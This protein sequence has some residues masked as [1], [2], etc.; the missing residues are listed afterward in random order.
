MNI[1]NNKKQDFNINDYHTKS[2][3]DEVN[4]F[5][6]GNSKLKTGKAGKF[7]I[8]DREQLYKYIVN[9][10]DN[11]LEQEYCLTESIKTN[12]FKFYID[13][14]IKDNDIK[15]FNVKELNREKFIDYILNCVYDCVLDY[16]NNKKLVDYVFC[17]KN[18]NTVGFHLYFPNIIIN[19]PHAISIIN[20]II[21]KVKNENTLKLSNESS[22]FYNKVIDSSIYRNG[23]GSLRLIY[24]KS[25]DGT[26]KYVNKG[27]YYLVNHQKTTYKNFPDDNNKLQQLMLLTLSCENENK[28]NFIPNITDDEMKHIQCELKNKKQNIKKTIPI[29]D[30]TKII[31]NENIE[32]NP[33]IITYL[34][35]L[36]ISRFDNYSDWLNIG[37]ILYNYSNNNINYL[38]LWDTYS[39]KS[40][41][42]TS[43][44]EIKQK[45]LSFNNNNKSLTIGTLIFMV[46]EDN[47]DAYNELIKNNNNTCIEIP[48]FNP[49]SIDIKDKDVLYFG[50]ITNQIH[51]EFLIDADE[52]FLN[53]NSNN[54][55]IQ[56]VNKLFDT[57]SD[58]K[59]V[60]V[61]SPYNSGKTSMLKK[62]IEQFD[63]KRV[64]FV[65]YR[66]SLSYDLYKNFNNL[67]FK[68][69]LN[70]DFSADRII[71]QI[72]SLEKLLP[73]NDETCIPNYDLVIIDEVVSV[74]NHLVSSPTVQ[75][76]HHTYDYLQAIL[77]NSKKIIAL[78]GDF[79]NMSYSYLSSFGKM[80]IIHNTI[81]KDKKNFIFHRQIDKF[82]DLINKDVQQKKKIVI[83]SL[84]QNMAMQYYDIYSKFYKEHYKDD[85]ERVY[86]HTS[87]SDDSNKEY[88]KDV[89]KTWLNS[90]ILIYTPSIESGIDFNIEHFDNLYIY[91]AQNSTSARGLLQM[92]SRV[93]K[94]K[95]NEV[96]VFLNNF[97]Y[98]TNANFFNYDEIKEWYIEFNKQSLSREYVL[99]EFPDKK[100]YCLQYKYSL[101]DEMSVYNITE[102]KNKHVS[103]FIPYLI[104]LLKDKGHSY[105]Y[106]NIDIENENKPQTNKKF[107]NI[108]KDILIKTKDINENEFNEYKKYQQYN[109]STRDQKLMI[110][111]YLFKKFWKIDN[112][113]NKIID[114]FFNNDDASNL[115]TE[116]YKELREKLIKEE[117]E[118]LINKYYNL[119]DIYNNLRGIIDKNY[120]LLFYD[121]NTYELKVDRIKANRYHKFKII[122]DII[123]KIG[124]DFKYIESKQNEKQI[125][126]SKKDLLIGIDNIKKKSLLYKDANSSLYFEFDKNKLKDSL[127]YQDQYFIQFINSIIKNY[128]LHIIS[129]NK[130]YQKNKIRYYD[131]N[132][133]LNINCDLIDLI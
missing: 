13:I 73:N 55:V 130:E 78:D 45:W 118:N 16:I 57:K 120:K 72:E 85:K 59:S 70:D 28:I 48:L 123:K 88:L 65:S 75:H 77:F 15:H 100:M 53:K 31:N 71:C 126:L 102:Q 82:N 69:Y 29:H 99:K 96:N 113:I 19:L 98:K 76:K 44:N 94:Y 125:V 52:S 124:Y 9:I 21:Y 2:K 112:K 83:I 101:F 61:K 39:K 87:L 32:V 109:I 115:T 17:E 49:P 114:D 56:A 129:I 116:E 128:G 60:C 33:I 24:V 41:K 36:N 119:E 127:N 84:S 86:V 104:Q 10:I 66:Q 51:K 26:H 62:I 14:D 11:N 80:C 81:K 121:N 20:K 6:Y 63:I 106:H 122:K 89:N 50:N 131:T 64:L 42:Y 34:D 35:L 43:Y 67:G 46:K 18:D 92:V 47:P 110:K 38:K 133:Y 1:E 95:N 79:N 40:S 108:E 107:F 22:G 103:Y 58:L 3:S 12:F 37:I 111:K 30:E 68:L 25:N 8:K 27:S 74:I 54:I 23:G 91:L 117:N 4:Y 90:D 5:S 7:I 97:K 105:S 93:R 132:F